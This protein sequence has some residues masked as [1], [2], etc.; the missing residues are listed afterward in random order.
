LAKLIEVIDL[1]TN[2]G[3]QGEDV[4][5]VYENLTNALTTIQRA[6]IHAEKQKKTLE[7]MLIAHKQNEKMLG[8]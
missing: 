1:I 7:N 5:A 2:N 6:S 3:A 4:I 8:L